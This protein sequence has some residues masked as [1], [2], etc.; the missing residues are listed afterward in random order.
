MP[1]VHGETHGGAAQTFA[2]HELACME[3]VVNAVCIELGV[4]SNEK[5]RRKAVAD[6]VF[7]AYRRAAT[8]YL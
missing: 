4:L 5:A 8:G 7:A 6:R 3:S 2:P 1:A